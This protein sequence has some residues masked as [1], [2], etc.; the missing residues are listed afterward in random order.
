M[1]SLTK[2]F[3]NLFPNKKYISYKKN[4]ENN[5]KTILDK[6]S[7]TIKNSSDIEN[8][9]ETPSTTRTN[10]PDIENFSETPDFDNNLYNYNYNYLYLINKNREYTDEGILFS[11]GELKW[12]FGKPVY[13]V[14]T[15]YYYFDNIISIY[16][17][18]YE[19][20]DVKIGFYYNNEFIEFT[21]Y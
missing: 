20:F 2:Y 4:Y 14:K 15:D 13:V 11:N 16:Y 12:I 3:T 18:L 1:N 5:Y 9:I 6:P 8:I 17:Y 21:Y 10:S 7:T 19:K